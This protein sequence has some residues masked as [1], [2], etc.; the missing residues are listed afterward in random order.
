MSILDKNTRAILI[1][2]TAAALLSVPLVAMRFTDEV[3]WDGR[4]FLIAGLLLFG[5]GLAIEIALRKVRGTMQ[6][7]ALCAVI[8]LILAVIWAEL[9]VGLI[10]TPLAGS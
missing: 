3:K 2:G 1:F 9:A 8:L 10:G 6:R 7:L 5:T 4:D